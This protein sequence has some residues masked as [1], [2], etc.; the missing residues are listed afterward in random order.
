MNGTAKVKV[1]GFDFDSSTP[2]QA[3]E[4]KEASK[5]LPWV[6][7]YM[8]AINVVLLGAWGCAWVYYGGH[9]FIVWL[10]AKYAPAIYM[11]ATHGMV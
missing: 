4:L 1:N 3:H 10:F 6:I 9:V 8:V 2:I 7:E 5:V 11:M